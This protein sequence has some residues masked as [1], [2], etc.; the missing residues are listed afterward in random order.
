M[1]KI[2]KEALAALARALERMSGVEPTEEERAFEPLCSNL[3]RVA[4]QYT[5]QELVE[6]DGL[7]FWHSKDF[8]WWEFRLNGAGLKLFFSIDREGDL[9]AFVRGDHYAHYL[10]SVFKFNR[11]LEEEGLR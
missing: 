1:T 10:A 3:R 4:R 5:W 11:I 7:L 6:T 9:S 8:S 2:K